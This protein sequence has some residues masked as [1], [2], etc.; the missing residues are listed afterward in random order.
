[1]KD[2]KRTIAGKIGME[3]KKLTT[4]LGGS[5]STSVFILAAAIAPFCHSQVDHPTANNYHQPKSQHN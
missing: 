3:L 2:N 5:S 4:L 1:M